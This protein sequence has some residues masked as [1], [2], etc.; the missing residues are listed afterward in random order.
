MKA[1]IM[2]FAQHYAETHDSPIPLVGDECLKVFVK[3][4][5]CS[6]DS[7]ELKAQMGEG[8]L[9]TL[10]SFGDDGSSCITLWDT[11][12]IAHLLDYEYF[13]R[14]EKKRVMDVLSKAVARLFTTKTSQQ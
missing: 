5:Y 6:E 13:S 12:G 1:K 9:V 10:K 14:A 8:E 11:N 4:G 7:E 3:W 2:K